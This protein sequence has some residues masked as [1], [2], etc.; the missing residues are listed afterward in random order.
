[1]LVYIIFLLASQL[2]DIVSEDI[3]GVKRKRKKKKIGIYP[4][5]Q[6][7]KQFKYRDSLTKHMRRHTGEDDLDRLF[8]CHFSFD[9]ILDLEIPL[10]VQD[11]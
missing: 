4:C 11:S 6:C 5:T 8:S 2:Q 1:M 9:K 10:F 3:G 7:D